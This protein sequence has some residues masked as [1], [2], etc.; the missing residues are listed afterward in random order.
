MCVIENTLTA[1]SEQKMFYLVSGGITLTVFLL[2]LR[3]WYMIHV[4]MDM[5]TS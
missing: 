3:L 1:Q 4:Y 2:L 5:F